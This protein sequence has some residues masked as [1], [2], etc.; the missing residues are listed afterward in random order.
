MLTPLEFRLLATPKA[1][2]KL[3][4]QLRDHDFDVRLCATE[5][6]ANVIDD[7]GEGTPV[8]IRVIGTPGRGRTRIEV[9]D[10]DPRTLPVLLSA[11]ESE[12]SGRGL[13]LLDAL[14]DGWGVVQEPDRKTV[15]CELGRRAFV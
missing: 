11:T 10:P 7:V 14:A 12:E 2:P 1:A 5:L 9:T 8:T 15:W 13:A 4:Y 3:R 6:L